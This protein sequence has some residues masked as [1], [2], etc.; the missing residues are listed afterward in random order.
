[1]GFDEVFTYPTV[2]QVIFQVKFPNL[3][4]LESKIGEL[5]LNVMREFPESELAHRRSVVF[6]DLPPGARSMDVAEKAEGVPWTKIWVFKSPNN[7]QLSVMSNSLDITTQH[8]TTYGAGEVDGF[9]DIIE[10]A[11]GNF[12]GVVAVPMFT[13]IGLRYIDECPMPAEKTNEAF[14][15]YYNSAFPLDRFNL[16]DAKEM[17]TVVLVEKGKHFMRYQERLQIRDDEPKLILDFD[18]FTQNV[19]A[20]DYLSVTDQLHRIISSE[21]HGVI[22]EPVKNYMRHG[23]EKS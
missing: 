7:Y 10:L 15:E 18:C 21:Y 2:K 19:L 3:F 1:M 4:Y 5:Q 14:K 6:A 12:L 8:H 16:S 23:G 13:Q 9:R 11:V 22:K 17:G 20:T